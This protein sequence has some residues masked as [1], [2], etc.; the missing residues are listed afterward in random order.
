MVVR[1]DPQNNEIRSLFNLVD[2]TGKRVLEIGSGDGRLTWRYA[3]S[4]AH[5]TAIEPFSESIRKGQGNLPFELR[6]R[7]EFFES[8]FLDFAAVSKTSIFDG[9]ILSWSLC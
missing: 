6:D 1:I 2:L 8:S 3:G 9:A 4:A 7:I 5:V